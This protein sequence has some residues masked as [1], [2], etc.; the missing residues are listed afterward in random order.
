ML[1]KSGCGCQVEANIATVFRLAKP[2]YETT[3]ATTEAAADGSVSI[4]KCLLYDAQLL[5]IKQ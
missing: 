1:H 4:Q 5:L 2:K 3:R